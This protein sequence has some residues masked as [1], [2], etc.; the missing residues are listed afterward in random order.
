MPWRW[1]IDR[2]KEQP[3]TGEW[4]LQDIRNQDHWPQ[5]TDQEYGT[6]L[7]SLVFL[8][9][10]RLFSRMRSLW[11]SVNS[12]LMG[13]T[14]QWRPWGRPWVRQCWWFFDSATQMGLCGSFAVWVL[15]LWE[16]ES[17]HRWPKMIRLAG[18]ALTSRKDSIRGLELGAFARHLQALKGLWG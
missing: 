6:R 14:S 10:F 3:V 13:D 4:A 15:L 17:F 11:I 8:A 9:I 18:A 2:P 7:W 5:D 16:W 12:Q 1:S